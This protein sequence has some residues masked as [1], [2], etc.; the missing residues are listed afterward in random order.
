MEMSSPNIQKRKL[1]IIHPSANV[2]GAEKQLLKFVSE[3]RED[4]S[5]TLIFLSPGG[6][7]APLFLESCANIVFLRK[8]H[9]RHWPT[10]LA[11]LGFLARSISPDAIYTFLPVPNILA[12]GIG[13]LLGI[14]NIY[15]GV[16]VSDF[17]S[18]FQ[19]RRDLFA[20][21]LQKLLSKNVSAII[22]NST[23]GADQAIQRGISKEKIH[24]VRNGIEIVDLDG[25]QIKTDREQIRRKLNISS[26][27]LVIGIVARIVEWKGHGI[28]LSAFKELNADLPNTRLLVVGAGK[29]ELV[30]SLKSHA[31]TL[32]LANSVSWIG[33]TASPYSWLSAFDVFVLPSV[34]GEGMSNAVAEAMAF[35]IPVAASNI[36]GMAELIDDERCLFPAGSPEALQ[37]ILN[38]YCKSSALRDSV[39]NA[40]RTR[41]ENF[42]S[43]DAMRRQTWDIIESCLKEARLTPN[44]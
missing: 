30:D 19:T 10:V 3:A 16:R 24:I 25:R 21:Y 38:R 8:T 7:L 1:L 15:W 43:I 32:G 13:K 18:Q 39:G 6:A 12:L 17:S 41:V 23:V 37:S 22:A 26:A 2:G 42:Y 11:K 33:E 20:D 4:W 5:I 31:N 9:W 29:P 27:M 14:S 40:G 35:G 34:A 36:G 44:H 28:L